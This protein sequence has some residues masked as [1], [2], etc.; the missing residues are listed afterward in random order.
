LAAVADQAQGSDV[1]QIAFA[2]A[3]C[4]RDNVIRIPQRSSIQPLQTPTRQQLLPVRTARPLQIEISSAAIDPANRTDALVARKYLL[5]QI[6]GVS[7]KA[8]FM[9][10]PVRAERESAR[11]DFEVTPAAERT[12]ILPSLEGSSVGKPAGHGPGSAH[13][14]FLA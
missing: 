14:T 12:A 4:H 2:T 11:R 10:A 8:P 1:F 7:A 9:D 13:Q 3:L 6:A 5:A